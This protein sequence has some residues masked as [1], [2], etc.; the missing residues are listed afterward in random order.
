MRFLLAVVLTFAP[1]AS[2]LGAATQWS[3][4]A[5]QSTLGFVAHWQ[6]TP[7]PGKFA[8]F[9]V[10]A[11]LDPANPSGGSLKVKI[12]TTS[13]SASSADVTRA[14]R[15]KDWFDVDRYPSATF[16]SQAIAAQSGGALKIMGILKLKG[17]SRTVSFPLTLSHEGNH[18]VLDG[19]LM[20]L[21]T[22]FDIGTGKWADGKIISVPVTIIFH[23][24]LG[25]A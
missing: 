7:V 4:L 21:R 19:Q 14:M 13:V 17:H 16:V 18:P 9:Q 23:V 10:T 20:L 8:K 1:C 5:D 12:V 24:V 2:V 22:G 3:S 11:Q 6:E 25:P 15:S